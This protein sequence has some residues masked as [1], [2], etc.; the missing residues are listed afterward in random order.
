MGLGITLMLRS[1]VGAFP[2]DSVI[3][4]IQTIINIPEIDFGITSIFVG[5]L[6]TLINFF[7][8]KNKKVFLSI[9]LLLGFGYILKF[10]HYVIPNNIYQETYYLNLLISLTGITIT[11]VGIAMIIQLNDFPLSPTEVTL[12]YFKEKFKK[13]FYAKLFIETILII[14]ALIL[15][16]FVKDFEQITL[17]SIISIPIS[18]MIVHAFDQLI[19]KFF[20][21]ETSY[22]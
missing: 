1:R 20:K 6:I 14:I 13:T 5:A 17:I 7:L 3:H 8:I 12:I 15:A 11:S 19:N 2:Y 9:T 22:N 21:L 4:Y 10:W 16:S 18:S